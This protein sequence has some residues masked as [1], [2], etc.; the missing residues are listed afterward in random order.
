MEEYKL[1]KEQR[2]GISDLFKFYKLA[3]RRVRTCSTPDA[4]IQ[5]MN[6]EK[7][8][9]KLDIDIKGTLEGYVKL[10]KEY[11]PHLETMAYGPTTEGTKEAYFAQLLIPYVEKFIPFAEETIERHKELEVIWNEYKKTGEIKSKPWTRPKE[12]IEADKKILEQN[13]EKNKE[14]RDKFAKEAKRLREE[15]EKELGI[16]PEPKKSEPEQY[17]LNLKLPSKTEKKE[18]KKNQSPYNF[19][20]MSKLPKYTQREFLADLGFRE[21][22]INSV[23]L[24]QTWENKLIKQGVKDH[25]AVR[26]LI[27]CT[28]KEWK[29]IE[30]Y[31]KEQK[32]KETLKDYLFYLPRYKLKQFLDYTDQ[33]LVDNGIE[34]SLLRK[35][36]P[37]CSE[38][39]MKRLKKI[40]IDAYSS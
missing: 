32:E 1:T 3:K 35:E 4:L 27:N 34:P 24:I 7:E 25:I 38:K 29:E 26:G 40:T 19:I 11:F 18:Q 16:S 17:T 36:T 28:E 6:D 20:A 21:T 23:Y 14:W 12:M 9:K 10:C 33:C 15:R 8:E 5:I 13:K 37:K 39:D 22:R 31:R 30:C 2:K